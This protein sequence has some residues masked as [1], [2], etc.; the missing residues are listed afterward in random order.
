VITLVGV[1]HVFDLKRQVREI[2]ASRQPRVVGIELDRVRWTALQQR[3]T[4]GDAPV[5][6]R[7]LSFFQERIADKYGGRVGDEMIAAADAAR[8]LG[9][10]LALIDRDSSEVF[11]Q[12]WGGMSFEERVKL[13]VAAVTSIF[14]TKGRVEKELARFEENNAAYLDEFGA[15]FPQAKRVLID[16]RNAH[17]ARVLR[18]LHASRGRVVAVVGDGHVEGLRHALGDLPIEVIRLGDLRAGRIPPAPPAPPEGPSVTFSY[19]V[20]GPGAG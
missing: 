17:M 4:R 12:V 20:G 16:E 6:Y 7:L 1:G 9:A 2:I 19:R 3:D 10:E 13:F 18:G 8:D 14:V 15:Q 11:Q 5:V